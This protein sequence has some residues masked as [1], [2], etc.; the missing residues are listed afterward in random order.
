MLVI[1]H[2]FSLL[3]SDERKRR[4]HGWA[5]YSLV[6]A[7]DAL[8]VQ[9][10]I[11]QHQ[12]ILTLE[13]E[14]RALQSQLHQIIPLYHTAS[15]TTA[16]AT[17]SK[18][19]ATT[20]D[21]ACSPSMTP[22]R[23]KIG[24][25]HS[26][27]DDRLPPATTALSNHHSMPSPDNVLLA[28]CLERDLGHCISAMHQA[29]LY[30]PNT[31][32]LSPSQV[33]EAVW[34][35]VLRLLPAQIAPADPTLI[36]QALACRAVLHRVA[37]DQALLAQVITSPSSLPIVSGMARNQLV[38][39]TACHTALARRVAPACMQIRHMLLQLWQLPSL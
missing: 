14:A 6:S 24:N 27:A 7:E 13:R 34:V 9:A 35:D 19:P 15:T 8:H 28:A 30:H 32:G 25:D 26:Y 21:P 12:Y 5:V 37:A 1:I 31:A 23:R 38:A 2:R 10:A 18:Y 33:T 29:Q 22:K 17:T 11:S 20:T 3:Y 39:V 36:A 4:A 16:A